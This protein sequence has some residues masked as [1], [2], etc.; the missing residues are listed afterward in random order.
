VLNKRDAYLIGMGFWV[1]VQLLVLTIQPG[2]VTYMLILAALGGIG[3][4]A[5]YTLPD[6][7]FA[8]V[9]EWDELRTGRRQEGI[10]FGV[11]AF[12]RKV[13][14]ALVIFVTLQS[15]G[16]SGYQTPPEGAIQFSQPDSALRMIR[17]LVSPLGAIML[18]GVVVLTAL[19][20][21]T[22]ERYE[23]MQKLLERRRGRGVAS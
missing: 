23:R 9:I 13:A 18:S 8:D 1:I 4:S 2:E 11:R 21:L 7:L 6:A 19:F 3:V 17:F 12:I 20:P 10:Y 5:A 22:R 16:W 15:L 14:G